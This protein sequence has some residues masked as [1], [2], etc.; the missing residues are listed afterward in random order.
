M[1]AALQLNYWNKTVTM[2]ATDYFNVYSFAKK[3]QLIIP[4]VA[5]L[6]AS[7]PFLVL[8]IVSLRQ[9][10]VSAIQGGF[11]QI[12]MTTIGSMT[13]RRAADGSSLGGE[14][15][16]PEELKRLRLRFGELV[17]GSEVGVRRAGFGTEDEVVPLRQGVSY[18]S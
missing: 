11:L 4:Y 1:N 13:L 17:G 5:C 9:N 15:N 10:G 8:G 16:V 2:T 7:A 14:E 18:S 3:Q 12:L 6:L